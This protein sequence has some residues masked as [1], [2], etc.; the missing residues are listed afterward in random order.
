MKFFI[1]TAEVNEIREAAALGILDGVTTNPSL[2]AKSGRAHKDVIVEI[3]SLVSG[4]V[5]VEVTADDAPTMLAQ[6]DDFITWADNVIIKVPLTAEGLKACKV[7]S[8]RGIGVNV[9]LCF[10]ANQAILAARAGAT[11]ISP[12]VGRLDDVGQDGM[13]LIEDIV[14]I[15]AN[16]PNLTT[17]VLVASVRSPI[18][19]H[20]S[21]LIGADVVTVPFNVI[22]QMFKH[23]LTDVG[24]EK[25]AQDWAKVPK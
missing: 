13:A 8:G 19:I 2:I 3:C 7:L 5:S 14:Q 1:D 20:K 18:H 25:F 22:K 16:Y 17:Q 10:S 15:Y 24:M 23:P 11:Y 4:P 12:F 6:A 9:T 21:A